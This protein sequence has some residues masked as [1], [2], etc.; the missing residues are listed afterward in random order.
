VTDSPFEYFLFPH[1]IVF[2]RELRPFFLL[3]PRMSVFQ[4][5]KPPDLP[6]PVEDRFR[7]YPVLSDAE[8]KARVESYLK[9]Y[10]DYA[11]LH[12]GEGF[13][14]L[15]GQERMNEDPLEES[16]FRIQSILKG[17]KPSEENMVPWLRLE[18]AVFL[19]LARD[20]DEK[21][22]EVALD[23]SRA[24]RLEENFQK[25][26]GIGTEEELKEVWNTTDTTEQ[27]EH[28]HFSVMLPR[29]MMSWYRLFA[30]QP[31]QGIPVAVAAVP[32]VAEELLDP[33]RTERERKNQSFEPLERRLMTFPSLEA[34]SDEDFQALCERLLSEDLL[35]S[36]WDR[37]AQ[38]IHAP[39]SHSTAEALEKEASQMSE[40]ISTFCS[41]RGNLSQKAVQLKLLCLDEDLHLRLWTK[42]DRKGR[43]ALGGRLPFPQKTVLLYLDD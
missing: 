7:A 2:K 32:D 35:S 26:L 9:G 17:K 29:R 6:S 11:G 13:R 36:Y 38:V 3:L 27:P 33:V 31:P 10:R 39:E 30:S 4:V 40:Q 12:R 18:A 14:E 43:E 23:F 20:L 42:L 24:S 25:A 19:E 22:R 5:L 41:E 15:L 1:T 37:L 8:E 16:R 28:A 34:L 21:E